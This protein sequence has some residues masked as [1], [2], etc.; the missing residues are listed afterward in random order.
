MGTLVSSGPDEAKPPRLNLPVDREVKVGRANTCHIRCSSDEVSSVHFKL[1]VRNGVVWLDDSSSNG[2][3]INTV[4]TTRGSAVAL[5]HMDQIGLCRPVSDTTR[6]VRYAFTFEAAMGRT[7]PA[8]TARLSFATP[9]ESVAINTRSASRAK[10]PSMA[11]ESSS[12][13]WQISQLD[14]NGELPSTRDLTYEVTPATRLR[15]TQRFST[16]HATCHC[17]FHAR[18]CSPLP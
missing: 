1:V 7:L 5:K 8:R 14:A 17:S 11:S 10:S 9:D 13:E 6:P 12:L 18:K 4:K 3:Y 2:T 15:T 16:S